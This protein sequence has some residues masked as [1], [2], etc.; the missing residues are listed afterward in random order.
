M[1]AI[2]LQ[3]REDTLRA[4]RVLGG[5][6]RAGDTIGLIGDL[7]AGK[8]TFVQGLAGGMG[9]DARVTSPTF[10]LVHEY[11]GPIPLFHFDPYR[12]ESLSDAFDLG[13]GEYLAR[14]GVLAVE[15]AERV[16]D[17]LPEDRLAV[18]LAFAGEGEEEEAREMTVGSG[19]PRSSVLAQ[20]WLSRLEEERT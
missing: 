12:L 14:G 10:V 18:A 13:L 15:W 5:L 7:G 17:L 6:V 9:I 16:G 3:S 8:T 20:Q 1:M 2:P 19:G 11:P 4:A